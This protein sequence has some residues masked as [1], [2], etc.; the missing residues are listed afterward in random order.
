MIV[1]KPKKFSQKDFSEED[2]YEF[3]LFWYVA[4]EAF[5]QK[6]GK[7]LYDFIDEDNF[8]TKEANYPEFEFSWKEENPESMKKICP[9]LYEEFVDK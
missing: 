5:Q 6:T 4:L 1:K 3:E 9:K 2:L 7:D 8:I